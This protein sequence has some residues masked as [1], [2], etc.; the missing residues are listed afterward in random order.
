[1]QDNDSINLRDE[2]D[3]QRLLDDCELDELELGNI[4]DSLQ[5]SMREENDFNPDDGQ[6][7]LALN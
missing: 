2:Q 7:D 5:E 4:C 1:M 3:D 6:S